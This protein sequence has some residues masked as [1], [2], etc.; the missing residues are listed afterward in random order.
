MKQ[1]IYNLRKL[2]YGR[3]GV[4]QLT[5]GLILLSLLLTLISTFSGNIIMTILAYIPIVYAM[6][7]VLSK[8]IQSRSKE[9]F[10]YTRMTGML[11]SKLRNF[12]LVLF[13][14]KTHKYYNCG[15]CRQIIRVPRGKGKICITCPKCKQEFVKRT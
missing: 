7:R 4:D 14:T 2:M 10:V 5:R 11:K 15:K 3:Y 12:G 13:G 9:N 1:L 6:F 8:N